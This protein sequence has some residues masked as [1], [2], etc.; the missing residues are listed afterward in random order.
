M[1]TR[2]ESEFG[3]GYQAEGDLG[4]VT[5]VDSA[6]KKGSGKVAFEVA[7]MGSSGHAMTT[8]EVIRMEPR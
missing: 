8:V 7:C 6:L 3:S 1:T 4:L 5:A 2:F